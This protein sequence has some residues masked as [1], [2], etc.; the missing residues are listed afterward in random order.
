MKA[1][2]WIWLIGA[3][4]YLIYQLLDSEADL[5]PDERT[6]PILKPVI[7]AFWFLAAPIQLTTEWKMKKAREKDEQA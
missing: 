2:F 6:P 1:V 5:S 4:V 7:A 3:V